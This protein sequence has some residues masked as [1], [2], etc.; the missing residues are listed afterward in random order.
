MEDA[1]T[2]EKQRE[3]ERQE[4]DRQVETERDKLSPVALSGGVRKEH[5]LSAQSN[6][7][8]FVGQPGRV[9]DVTYA[10]THTTRKTCGLQHTYKRQHK[11]Q[12]LDID[13]QTETR[14]LDSPSYPGVRTPSS[15][16]R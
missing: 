15:A 1:K 4:Y 14:R 7:R 6:W 10:R 12:A 11:Q 2:R 5:R 13:R 8:I 16:S 9:V 3:K